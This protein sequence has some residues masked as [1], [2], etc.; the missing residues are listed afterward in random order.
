MLHP[1]H[2]VVERA[3][4]AYMTCVLQ[5]QK[6]HGLTPCETLEIITGDLFGMCRGFVNT[7]RRRE[8]DGK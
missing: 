6:E 2:D 8:G 5:W 3:R 4:N 7:E 1:R